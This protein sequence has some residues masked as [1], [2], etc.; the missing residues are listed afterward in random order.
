MLLLICV[1]FSLIRTLHLSW[2]RMRA[3]CG[4]L[5]TTPLTHWQLVPT[6]P[7]IS[8]CWLSSSPRRSHTKRLPAA[9]FSRTKVHYLDPHTHTPTLPICTYALLSQQSSTYFNYFFTIC[10]LIT[11]FR[12][13]N[14]I[15]QSSFFPRLSRE[16]RW[17][18]WRWWR[19]FYQTPDKKT[20]VTKS[21]R[22]T[23]RHSHVWSCNQIIIFFLFLLTYSQN[24]C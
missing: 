17:W 23:R 8:P 18:C 21:E 24:I 6:A 3:L 20:Q 14:K 1:F 2:C 4:A 7:Q 22:I 19:S 9:T 10:M 5:A 12:F 15:F 16:Q 13:G 11:C